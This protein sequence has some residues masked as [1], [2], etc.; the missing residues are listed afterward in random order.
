MT[1][2]EA[3]RV[4]NDYLLMTLRKQRSTLSTILQINILQQTFVPRLVLKSSKGQ[5]WLLRGTF[6]FCSGATVLLKEPAKLTIIAVPSVI[7]SHAI[8]SI[9]HCRQVYEPSFSGTRI[10]R[11]SEGL[12]SI[13]T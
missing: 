9:T 8:K 1:F 4:L 12:L 13:D 3:L 7:L 5:K 10:F 11:P 2:T 6:Y